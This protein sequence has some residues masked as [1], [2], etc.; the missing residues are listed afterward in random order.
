MAQYRVTWRHEVIFNAKDDE[1]AKRR[2]T[3]IDLGDLSK[4]CVIAHDY[5]ELKSFECVS[6]DYREVQL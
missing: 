4:S 6:D 1:E 5:I 2:W 3:T